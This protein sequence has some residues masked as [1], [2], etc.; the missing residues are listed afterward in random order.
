M[1]VYYSPGD[2]YKR[3]I[4]RTTCQFQ[5]AVQMYE[6]VCT[7][8]R[9]VGLGIISDSLNKTRLS[10]LFNDTNLGLFDALLRA[11]IIIVDLHS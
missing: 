2:V 10:F 1:K 3:Q 4:L 6:R 11:R 5:F 9:P 7:R 8:P